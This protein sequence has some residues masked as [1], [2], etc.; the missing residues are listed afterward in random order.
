MLSIE[1]ITSMVEGVKCFFDFLFRSSFALRKVWVYS[2]KQIIRGANFTDSN[3]CDEKEDLSSVD[4]PVCW[5]LYWASDFQEDSQDKSYWSVKT[6]FGDFVEGNKNNLL[7][8]YLGKFIDV[9]ACGANEGQRDELQDRK[10]LREL[11]LSW[12]FHT[13]LS[14]Q[15]PVRNALSILFPIFEYFAQKERIKTKGKNRKTFQELMEHLLKNVGGDTELAKIL[16]KYRDNVVAHR[17]P[18]ISVEEIESLHNQLAERYEE[19]VVVVR[20]H[21]LKI[22]QPDHEKFAKKL[23]WRAV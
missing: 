3:I 13:Y 11:I 5:Q 17:D 12:I 9:L 2:S 4:I 21:F 15:Q 18:D 20:F 19:L 14:P 10:V 22:L 7:G 6:G 16:A 8:D 1:E 23:V